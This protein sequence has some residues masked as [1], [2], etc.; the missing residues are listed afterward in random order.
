M[1][2]KGKVGKLRTRFGKGTV[3]LLSER[4]EQLLIEGNYSQALHEVEELEK[5][6]DFELVDQLKLGVLKSRCFYE[7]NNCQEALII[8]NSVIEQG[9]TNPT[10][11]DIVVE[12]YIQ[13]AWAEYQLGQFKVA[14]ESVET[15]E[16]LITTSIEDDTPDN[17][18]R[19]GMAL[20][21]KGCIAT[22]SQLE[23]ALEYLSQA[24]SLF[25][26]IG[27][28][29]RMAMALQNMGQG[30][31]S[32]GKSESAFDYYDK[33]KL[34]FQEV[35]NRLRLADIEIRIGLLLGS[36]GD[37][38]EQMACAK[39]ALMIYEE[40][41]DKHR[42]VDTLHAIGQCYLSMGELHTALGY[43][44]K[45]ILVCKETSEEGQ[46]LAWLSA[47]IG[48]VYRIRREFDK[49][50][51]WYEKALAIAR[52]IGDDS[53]ISVY[54]SSI[55]VLLQTKGELDSS[56]KNQK[57][58]LEKAEIIGYNAT[59]G[60]ILYRLISV[61]L[62]RN[63]IDLAESY[64]QSLQKR[65][66]AQEGEDKY[67]DQVYRVAQSLILKTSKNP[68]KRAKAEEL[69]EQVVREDVTYIE[70]TTDALLTL[71]SMLLD[72]LRLSGDK[73]VLQDLK[74]FV[75][76]L[77]EIAQKQHSYW[78]LAESYWLQS[79]MSL[80]ELKPKEALQLLSQAQL[81][82]EG[83]GLNKLALKISTEYDRLLDQTENWERLA[84]L[85]APLAERLDTAHI[86]E[87]LERMVKKED[88]EVPEIEEEE[89]VQF[90][91]VA[92]TGGVNLV[93]KSFQPGIAMDE[94]LVS[95]FLSA[96]S[97]F[98]EEIFSQSLDRVRIGE[99]TM[100]M[101]YE[102]PFLFCYVFKG[103]SYSAIQKMKEFIEIL[104]GK[105]S[106]REALERT[107][108]TG[109]INQSAQASVEDVLTQV[110]VPAVTN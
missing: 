75:K 33:A 50:L 8:A 95:G 90:L 27:D 105:E 24:H 36:R 38:D 82:A 2:W 88:V 42:I 19:R 80:V 22:Y 59:I 49:A 30:H 63:N 46:H 28:K 58:S 55:G 65:C 69:L 20:R 108:A 84:E 35:G 100:L 34:L 16:M 7:S 48:Q 78:L 45:G 61:A 101:Q 6:E 43:F 5:E 94:S 40:Y 77:S 109:A 57:E 9:K 39:R 52:R 86:S 97:S 96:L 93:T 106:L 76:Q 87:Q 83:H 81:I 66:S 4:V 14:M 56:F 26:E 104:R 71:C 102:E 99:Y 21:L 54:L 31:G 64:L 110:F 25:V 60:T 92:A 41:D 11:T 98:S 79:Q 103:Q 17:K 44:D 3:D 68:R 74:A 89:P 15:G 32:I 37:T 73:E 85:D 18:L 62:G 53:A 107:V 70:I 72:D 10:L 51:K 12:V 47:S 13:K 29:N 23:L 91:L 1:G 67:L